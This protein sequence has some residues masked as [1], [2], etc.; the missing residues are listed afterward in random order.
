MHSPVLVR[1]V[2]VVVSLVVLREQPAKASTVRS[3]APENT[4][5]GMLISN[6]SF[7]V[8]DVSHAGQL[9]TKVLQNPFVGKYEIAN[10]RQPHTIVEH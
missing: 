1:G 10:A 8:F 3:N 5:I 9:I 4:R 6:F 2:L 7:F